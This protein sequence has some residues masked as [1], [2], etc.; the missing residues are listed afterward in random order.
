MHRKDA[1]RLLSL[2]ALVFQTTSLVLLLRYSRT[3]K[4]EPYLSSTAVVLG[5]LLKGIICIIFVWIE[6]GK[7]IFLIFHRIEIE[8]IVNSSSYFSME[9][10]LFPTFLQH[11]Q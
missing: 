5:E 2:I 6:N 9:R 10:F 11:H 3:R 8:S 7:S 4:V 1:L